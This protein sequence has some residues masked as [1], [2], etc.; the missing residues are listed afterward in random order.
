MKPISFKIYNSIENID[1]SIWN[2]IIPSSRF[3]MTYPYFQSLEKAVS[4]LEF[5]YLIAFHEET[6]VGVAS[7]QIANFRGEFLKKYLPEKEGLVKKL[8]LFGLNKIDVKLITLGNLVSTGDKGWSFKTDNETA[9]E[10]I[11]SGLDTIAASIKNKTT[12]ILICK[13]GSD[14]NMDVFKSHHFHPYKAEDEMHLYIPKNWN[15]FD[16][17]ENSMHSKYRVR[18]HKVFQVGHGMEL[19]HL[20]L[21]AI[22]A[23][24]VAIQALFE[25][26]LDHVKFKLVHLDINYFIEMKKSLPDNFH[27]LAYY[28]KETLIAF[29]S[30]FII[31][32][33]IDVH[34]IGIDYNYNQKFKIY[35]RVLF[36]MTKMGITNH[37]EMVCFGRTAHEI[38]STVGAVPEDVYNYLRINNRIFNPLIPFFLKRLVPQPWIQR[39]P[40]K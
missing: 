8:L 10:T 6:P 33:D 4:D 36:D 27:I 21:D 39:N 38:K 22:L 32:D 2:T 15:S 25:N 16:D 30:Y 23:Q 37:K 14:K 31:H 11:I 26:V 24:K 7:F 1:E 18:M 40:F 28:Y 12:G 13:E 20:S 3:F 5:R 17:Y 35:N 19:K 9:L 34:Y 29:I